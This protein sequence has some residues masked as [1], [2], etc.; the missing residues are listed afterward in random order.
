MRKDAEQFLSDLLN[1]PSPSGSEQNVAKIFRNRVKGFAE[2]VYGDVHGNSF[3]V[4]N[5][6]AQF[7][8]MLAGHI[9]EIG[10]MV[11]YIDDKGFLSVAQ[12]GGM[13]TNLL[14]GQRVKV[15]T[16]KGPVSGVVGRQAI[17]LMEPEERTKGVQMANVWIDIGA[18]DKKQAQKLVSV[19]D[20]IVIDVDYQRLLDDRIIARGCDDRVGAFVVAETIRALAKKKL[21]ICVVGVATVQEEIGLRGATTS[22]YS[23]K[24]DAGIAIDVGFATD[25]PEAKPKVVGEVNIGDGPVLHRGPNMNPIMEKDLF[26]VAKANK[27]PHQVTG[28]ARGTGTDANVMQLNRG[29]VAVSLVSIPNR[30]MHT[31]VE[32][33]SLKDLDNTVKLLTAYLQ[34]FP[35]T[36]DFRP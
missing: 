18:K 24:P 14:V 27:I 8:F 7:K 12:I 3:A 30:Y 28:L 13:D 6:K 36:K 20:P 34:K 10:L 31:P 23:V 29:G 33:I 9:D 35:K 22:S 26:R 21:N 1:M 17:H 11:M 5:P 32:M 25:H 19:G 2:E 16:A 4:L 15:I